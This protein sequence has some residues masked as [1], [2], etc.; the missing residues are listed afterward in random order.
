MIIFVDPPSVLKTIV[1]CFPFLKELSTDGVIVVRFHNHSRISKKLS[2]N[3]FNIWIRFGLFVWS[4]SSR[5]THEIR[6]QAKNVRI[7]HVFFS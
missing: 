3:V 2:G 5:K 1:K 7:R 4:L 6:E